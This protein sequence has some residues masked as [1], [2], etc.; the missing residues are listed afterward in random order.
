MTKFINLFKKHCFW[1]IFG[2]FSQFW[3]QN[4]FSRKSVSVTHNFIWVSSIMPRYNSKKRPGQTEGQTEGRKDVQ[5]L[6]HRTLPTN[7]GGPIILFWSLLRNADILD[8]AFHFWLE[9]F[10][11]ISYMTIKIQFI[12]NIY[13]QNNFFLSVFI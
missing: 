12:I 13:T 6:F 9:F 4:F 8:R 11:H 7:A 3:G 1:R 10:R 5:T 2:P